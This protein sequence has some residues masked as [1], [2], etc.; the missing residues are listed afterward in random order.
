[1]GICTG[2]GGN[3]KLHHIPKLQAIPGVEVVAIANRSAE[4][5]AKAGEPFGIT[6]VNYESTPT[7]KQCD[8]DSTIRQPGSRQ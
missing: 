8:G 5:A 2:A 4:S 6:K 1:M 3:T 7:F